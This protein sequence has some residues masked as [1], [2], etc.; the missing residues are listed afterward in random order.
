PGPWNLGGGLFKLFCVLS[1]V[2]MVIIFYI[3][4]QPPN[5]KVLYITIGFIVLT[6]VLWFG[7]ENRRF[8]GP[9]IGDQI[10]K[11]QAAIAAAELAVG[12]TGH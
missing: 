2:G 11:R 7:F 8:K 10:A 12:E 4:I 6:A 9:P 5:D 3:A 1:L